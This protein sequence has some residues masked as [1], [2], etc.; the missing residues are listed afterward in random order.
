LIA[1]A[2][3]A[4]ANESAHAFG[5]KGW[6]QLSGGNG[7]NSSIAAGGGGPAYSF[8]S[9]AQYA[10]TAPLAQTFTQDIGTASADR[11]VVVGM[12]GFYPQSGG[13]TS[14]TVN[15]VTLTQ[16]AFDN[17]SAGGPHAAIFS[18]PVTSG[19]GSQNIVVT[20]GSTPNGDAIGIVV[21]ALT[22]LGSNVHRTIGGASSNAVLSV[23]VMAGHLLFST[24]L[25]NSGSVT[26]ASSTE[27]PTSNGGAV[28]N[29]NSANQNW[30]AD[31]TISSTNAAF[32]VNPAVVG[33]STT[34]AA[35]FF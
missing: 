13:I 15:G 3:V 10:G 31:W 27:T 1:L 8:R 5:C 20:Y 34:V 35:T 23:A 11:V 17:R 28:H 9:A 19:S 25:I 2:A 24:S 32:S 4:V 12:S 16:D 29:A 14:V 21:W 26:Y 18:G 30:A 7:C 6:P 22:G 33:A